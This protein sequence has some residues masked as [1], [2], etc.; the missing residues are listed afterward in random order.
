MNYKR[1]KV[2][3]YFKSN[4]ILNGYTYLDGILAYAKLRREIGDDIFNLKEEDDPI[5]VDIP[6]Q[7]DGQVFLSSYA[8]MLEKKEYVNRWRKR[9]DVVPATKYVKDKKVDTASGY[10]KNYDMPVAVQLTDRI[11]WII[12]GD[13][14]EIEDLLKDIYYIGKKHAQGYGLIDRWEVVE[15][16]EKGLRHFPVA[17]VTKG[18]TVEFTGFKP[19]YWHRK[20]IVTCAIR[21]F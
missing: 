12:V 5:E 6:V 4:P 20:C 11:S 10:Y 1:L 7:K 3:A 8:M 18:E 17:N 13:K 14:E 2:T 15:T 9:L 19:P 16:E 21:E